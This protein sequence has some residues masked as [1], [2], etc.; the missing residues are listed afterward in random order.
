MRIAVALVICLALASC[1]TSTKAPPTTFLIY[2]PP[3]SA[4][5][6]PNAARVLNELAAD[7]NRRNAMVEVSGPTAKRGKHRK[8]SLAE[9]RTVV[10]EHALIAAGVAEERVQLVKP[11]LV[12]RTRDPAGEPV[13]V[14]L[15][16]KPTV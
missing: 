15:V 10:V 2:F 14:R 7:A 5:L 3:N 1:A 13:Q 6:L 16:I 8:P 12:T 9:Q 11:P 4:L